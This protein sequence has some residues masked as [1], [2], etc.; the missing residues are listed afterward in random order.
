MTQRTIVLKFGSSVL[1]TPA[2]LPNVVHE[3]YRWY[4]DGWRVVAVVSALDG[5]TDALLGEARGISPHP[6]P[7]ALAELLAT[8]ERRSAA[9]L[10]I[11][12]DR[13]G[14][15]ARV[16]DPREARF[17]S[18]GTPLD[19]TP[20]GLD[21][22]VFERWFA[23]YA[24]IVFPGFFG[25]DADGRLQLLGRGGSD[26]SAVF[27]AEALDA[28]R[29][30]LLKDVD[31]VYESDPATSGA[32]CVRRYAR[33]GYEDALER[34]K[35]LIQPKAVHALER[36]QRTVHVAALG[37]GYSSAIGPFEQAFEVPHEAPRLRVLLLGFGTVGKSAYSMLAQMPDH[38]VVAGIFVRHRNK[39]L[40]SG[41][42]EHL[43]IDTQEALAALEVDVV[44][45]A[46][47]GF[48]PSHALIRYFLGHGAHVVSANKVLI[49]DAEPELQRIAAAHSTTLRYGAAA[50]GGVPMIETVRLASAQGEIASIEAILNGTTNFV[51]SGCAAGLSFEAAIRAAQDAG[52]AE[53]DPSEDLSGRD[54]T[55]KLVIL[56]RIAFGREPDVF[57]RAPIDAATVT[58]MQDS[59]RPGETL[60]QIARIAQQDGRLIA[61]VA[62][63]P[64]GV[65][66]P[67][68]RTLNECNHLRIA[69]ADGRSLSVF[70][71]GAGGMPTAEAILGDLIELSCARQPATTS[72]PALRITS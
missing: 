31:G 56:S 8:G 9:L 5:T 70:G 3:I 67:F 21:R 2:D 59:L 16:S 34:A 63:E 49:A 45:D 27:I 4:R 48:E 61:R 62:L 55:R 20:R 72:E 39:H 60:R 15:P 41:I 36:A 53:L 71:R 46:L 35:Q 19:A 23:D 22:T 13:A 66:E 12:L 43:L 50:G 33:L 30:Y 29:C 51:L 57:T 28:D 7:H 24:V 14:V 32:Y 1:R 10:G 68:G 64:V 25:Y 52:F 38:F 18:V 58:L 26:L 44:V 11:A 37:R 65:E 6:E 54:A 40:G 69:F 42:P 17:T 47:P